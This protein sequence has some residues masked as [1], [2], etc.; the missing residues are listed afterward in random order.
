VNHWHIQEQLVRER[1]ADYAREAARD[2]R[3]REVRRDRPD[4]GVGGRARSLV[5]AAVAWIRTRRGALAA[6]TTLGAACGLPGARPMVA[7]GAWEPID[8]A[9]HSAVGRP[10]DPREAVGAVR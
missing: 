7:S 5:A 8:P 2:R 10:H 6:D 9:D 4:R 1:H 3:A